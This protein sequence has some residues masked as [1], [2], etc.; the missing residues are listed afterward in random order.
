MALPLLER[1]H[2]GKPE[3]AKFAMDY[4][5]VLF[6][7]ERIEARTLPRPATRRPELFESPGVH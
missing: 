2:R 7:G 3:S 1:A 5:R 6:L 4:A